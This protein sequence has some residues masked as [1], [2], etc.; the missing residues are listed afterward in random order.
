MQKRSVTRIVKEI[1][2][3]KARIVKE[4]DKLDALRDEL[5]HLIGNCLEAEEALETARD[6]LS[7]LL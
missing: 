6:A 4:R 5:E 1:D 3:S 7:E 2:A